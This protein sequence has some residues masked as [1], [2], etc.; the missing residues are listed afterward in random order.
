MQTFVYK[1]NAREVFLV[2]SIISCHRDVF[3]GFGNLLGHFDEKKTIKF[4]VIN[5]KRWRFCVQSL[6][7]IY[8]IVFI[9][10]TSLLI[11]L[12]CFAI[13]CKDNSLFLNPKHFGSFFIRNLPPKW[14]AFLY[15]CITLILELEYFELAHELLPFAMVDQA[16]IWTVFVRMSC[17]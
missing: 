1:C 14:H 13:Y 5:H 16:E 2:V 8:C 9:F 15:F 11:I 6:S 4:Q 12:W 3:V 7:M 10:L 17:A